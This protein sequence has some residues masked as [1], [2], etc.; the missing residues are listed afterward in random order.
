LPRST[1]WQNQQR[2]EQRP[3]GRSDYRESGLVHRCIAVARLS[4][5]NDGNGSSS[6]TCDARFEGR[7][8]TFEMNISAAA[9]T[10]FSLGQHR[11]GATDGASALREFA[12][13]R[14]VCTLTTGCVEC[15][16]AFA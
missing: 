14:C 6:T 12:V 5:L 15:E 8:L 4:E 7:L 9:V 10:S 11:I 16:K 1:T 2:D 13:Q 3:L